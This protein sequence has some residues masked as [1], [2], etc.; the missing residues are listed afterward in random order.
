MAYHGRQAY[1]QNATYT[2]IPAVTGKIPVL[3]PEE[4]WTLRAFQGTGAIQSLAETN[5]GKNWLSVEFFAS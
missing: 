5:G 4:I 1:I 2:S 3:V